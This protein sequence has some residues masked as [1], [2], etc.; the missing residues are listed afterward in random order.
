MRN[1]PYS[2]LLSQ[3]H[4]YLSLRLRDSQLLLALLPCPKVNH[5]IALCT[6]QGEWYCTLLQQLL[7]VAFAGVQADL[8]E[9]SFCDDLESKLRDFDL[10]SRVEIGRPD[11]LRSC[12][13]LLQVSLRERS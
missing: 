2:K 4:R 13:G 11:R 6:P 1:H 12:T 10:V 9:L 7:S 8:L 5:S 3:S